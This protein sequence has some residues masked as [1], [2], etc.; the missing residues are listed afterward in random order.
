MWWKRKKLRWNVSRT[1]AKKFLPEA[2]YLIFKISLFFHLLMLSMHI[3]LFTLIQSRQPDCLHYL[4]S[5]PVRLQM[6]IGMS[7]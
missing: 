7:D 6:Q 3:H 2:A 1:Q 4:N 5:I